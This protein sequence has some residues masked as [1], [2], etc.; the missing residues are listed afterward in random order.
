M[1]PNLEKPLGTEVIY[2]CSPDWWKRLCV[3][4][5]TLLE[6]GTAV[7]RV[8][9][10]RV[11]TE[12]ASSGFGD[13]LLHVVD[14]PPRTEAMQAT[15]AGFLA[16]KTYMCS[17]RASRVVYLDADTVVLRPLDPVW[18][19]HSSDVI[20]RCASAYEK[21]TWNGALWRATLRESGAIENYPYLNSGFVVFQNGVTQLLECPWRN[22][23][24]QLSGRP[25]LLTALHKLRNAEQL[26]LSLAI[27]ASRLSIRL[28]N[29]REHAYGWRSE[30]RESA[31]LY[32]TGSG[33]FE[34]FIAAR[35]F[36]LDTAEQDL[37][38]T[39][40]DQRRI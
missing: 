25:S 18:N 38:R 33:R 8:T 24:R 26:A 1:N 21:P 39:V 35:G 9:I 40:H 29:H 20:A 15:G 6:S 34:K 23:I 37:V 31:L 30:P 36:R 12:P 19:N 3:S 11:A 32:H 17:S 7:D 14:V 28:M 10:Y 4:V 2:V 13:D 27:A 22:L 16:N 5:R